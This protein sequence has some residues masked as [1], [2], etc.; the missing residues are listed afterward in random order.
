MAVMVYRSMANFQVNLVSSPIVKLVGHA[1]SSELS[2][3]NFLPLT[4]HHSYLV[5]IYDSTS[6]KLFILTF[7][8]HTFFTA[9]LFC[10]D[11]SE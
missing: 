4:Y 9:W 1:N 7:W 3:L 5:I 6:L 2:L 8:G 10:I 11:Y